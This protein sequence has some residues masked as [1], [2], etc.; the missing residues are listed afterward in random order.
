MEKLTM[1]CE[2]LQKALETLA[3]SLQR[4]ESKTFSNYQE[5]RDSLIQRF[6]YSADTFWKYLKDYLQVT[7]NVELEV[8]RPRSILKECAETKIITQ[9]EFEQCILLIESRNMTSHGYN[10]PLAEEISKKI[11]H[12]YELMNTIVMRLGSCKK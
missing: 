3:E 1:R 2:T 6:E 9:D 12:Y 5:W 7:M 11:P 10:E 4:H 8:A